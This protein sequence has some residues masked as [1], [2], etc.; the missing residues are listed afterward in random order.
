MTDLDEL[1]AQEQRKIE[2]LFESVALLLKSDLIH[3]MD[4]ETL[5]QLSRLRDVVQAWV[6]G[7]STLSHEQM[8]D[9]ISTLTA[10]LAQD[11]TILL[12]ERNRSLH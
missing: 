4:L 12:D 8:L 6:A 7:T 3:W 11:K 5:D 2:E 9:T 1:A 10:A